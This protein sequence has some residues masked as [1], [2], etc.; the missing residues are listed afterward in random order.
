MRKYDK[1]HL[2]KRDKQRTV[3]R[4]QEEKKE[5]QKRKITCDKEWWR[6]NHPLLLEVT[7]KYKQENRS[8]R[9]GGR[10]VNVP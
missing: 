2:R 7:L 1:I 6:V 4:K 9:Y 10:L 3:C 5:Y 8:I